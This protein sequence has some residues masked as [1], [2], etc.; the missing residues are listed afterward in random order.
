[1][2]DLLSLWL[3][4]LTTSG[5]AVLVVNKNLGA[6][7]LHVWMES[8]GWKVNRLKSFRGFRLLEVKRNA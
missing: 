4:R 5:T 6:D 3:N 7:S 1:M 8:E 2:M